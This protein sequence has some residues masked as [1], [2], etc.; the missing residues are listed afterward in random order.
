MAVIAVTLTLILKTAALAAFH[1]WVMLLLTPTLAR[2]MIL[3][4]FLWLPYAKEYG[5]GGEIQ[6]ILADQ[7]R[8]FAMLIV[9]V[10]LLSPLLFAGLWQWLLLTAVTA[11]TFVLW[12]FA[13]KSRLQGFTGNCIGLLVELSELVLLLVFV[14]YE[15]AT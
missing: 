11:V 13:M 12:R 9:A 6:L 5:L 3:P 14:T 8:T 4:A 2:I 10:G 7:K 15:L 1:N